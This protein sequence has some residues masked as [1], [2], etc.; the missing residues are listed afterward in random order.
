MRSSATRA[1]DIRVLCNWP[2][3]GMESHK[4]KFDYFSSCHFVLGMN[5]SHFT[6]TLELFSFKSGVGSSKY[7][8]NPVAIAAATETN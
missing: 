7:A 5:R 3:V 8:L 4:Q 2:T 6:T 1:K